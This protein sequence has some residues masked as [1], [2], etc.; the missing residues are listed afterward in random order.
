MHDAQATHCIKVYQALVAGRI[1]ANDPRLV[2]IAQPL[3]GEK[4]GHE[5]KVS[6]S[7]AV[8]VLRTFRD[9]RLAR[10]VELC[11]N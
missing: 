4:G 11:V 2:L 5:Y 6:D 3:S 7:A 9:T 8:R 10:P 1:E